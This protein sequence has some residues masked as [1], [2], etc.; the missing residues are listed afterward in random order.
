MC[1]VP[2][3]LNIFFDRVVRQDNERATGASL[4]LR[5][6]NGG[7]WETEQVLYGYDKMLVAETR[8]HLQLS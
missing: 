8:E 4:K 2:V 5:D 7:G 6:E 3:D 1:N